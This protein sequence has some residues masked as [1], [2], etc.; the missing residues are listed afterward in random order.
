M[1]YMLYDDEQWERFVA[2][3]KTLLENALYRDLATR[4]KLPASSVC[5]LCHQTTWGVS[6]CA[7]E[8]CPT[9]LKPYDG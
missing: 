1:T 2:A 3:A 6:F 7:N 8:G 5:N 9:G 4:Y